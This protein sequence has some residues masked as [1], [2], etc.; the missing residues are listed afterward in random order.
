M[1][2]RRATARSRSAGGD[3]VA[4]IN[5]SSAFGEVARAVIAFTLDL[6]SGD[7]TGV[8]SQE[9][10][11]A[12]RLDLALAY[13]LETVTVTTD[14]L[15]PAEVARFV[16]GGE[17]DRRVAD[18]LRT[19]S[20]QERLGAQSWEVVEVVRNA[21]APVGADVVSAAIDGLTRKDASQYLRRLE[22]SGFLTRRGRGVYEYR[23]PL[24]DRFGGG[25]ESVVSN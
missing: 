3:I 23:R 13:T 20:A 11:N 10:N 1:P 25:E 7:G 14:D 18:V 6:Q 22:R 8:L 15:L 5:G 24:A 21:N 4:A 12:G 17:S 2:T 19:N 16:L 9:K